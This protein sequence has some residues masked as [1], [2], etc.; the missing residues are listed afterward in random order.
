MV[1]T[2]EEYV[3]T[4]EPPWQDFANPGYHRVLGGTASKQR[5]RETQYQAAKGIY[6]SQENVRAA[7]NKALTA[8][9]LTT[10]RRAKGAVGPPVYTAT[11]NPEAIL[12]DL[13]KRYGR[14]TPAE[15]AQQMPP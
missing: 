5:D 13:Q 4:G 15:K 10:F 6:I 11:D 2:P 7:I 12:L 3:L 9:V 1:V 14:A 8:A